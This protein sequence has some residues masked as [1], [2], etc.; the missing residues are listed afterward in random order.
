MVKKKENYWLSL[1]KLIGV[2]VVVALTIALAYQIGPRSGRNAT[3]KEIEV[4]IPTETCEYSTSDIYYKGICDVVQ[5]MLGLESLKEELE[6]DFREWEEKEYQK[7]KDKKEELERGWQEL[8]KMRNHDNELFK[9][10]MGVINN[11]QEQLSRG[12]EDLNP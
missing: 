12:I 10:Q 2:V 4:N 3:I 6:R 11:L 1:V 8:D 9:R 7:I 5:E